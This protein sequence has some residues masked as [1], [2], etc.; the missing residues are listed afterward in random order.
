M[1]FEKYYANITQNYVTNDLIKISTILFLLKIN[2]ND[3]S[4]RSDYDS[5]SK[6]RFTNNVHWTLNQIINARQEASALLFSS[7]LNSVR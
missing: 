1:G 6:A 7:A 3:K 5:A 4:F 2:S